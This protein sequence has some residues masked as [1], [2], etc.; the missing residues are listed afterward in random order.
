MVDGGGASPGR[1]PSLPP[2]TGWRLLDRQIQRE[3]ALKCQATL[4]HQVDRWRGAGSMDLALSRWPAHF[5]CGR[6]NDPRP[7]AVPQ[8]S[9]ASARTERGV[10][11]EPGR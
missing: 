2:K 1:R 9:S 6:V 8:A 11:F 4:I 5:E 10:R 3:E 7:T